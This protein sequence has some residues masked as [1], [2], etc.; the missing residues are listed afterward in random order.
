MPRREGGGGGG[1][2]GGGRPPRPN[3]RSAPGREVSGYI[4]TKVTR[5]HKGVSKCI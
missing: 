1:G 3:A 2:G 4:Y 5:V